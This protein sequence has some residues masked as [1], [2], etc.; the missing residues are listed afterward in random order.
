MLNETFFFLLGWFHSQLA[1][2]LGRYLMTLT[3]PTF[4]ILQDIPGFS[5]IVSH[6]VVYSGTCMTHAWPQQ[7]S[8][9]S[10]GNFITPF[11]HLSLTQELR[12]QNCQVLLFTGAG[13]WLSCSIIS[14]P[15]FCFQWFPSLPNIGYPETCSIYLTSLK[16]RD[17]LASAFWVLIVK[18]CTTA[19]NTKLFFNS[20]SQIRNLQ[21]LPRDHH[22]LYSFS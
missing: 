2:F 7:C 4:W 22:C 6:H 20:F 9:K 12:G 11:F 16:S 13:T 3:T 21:G 10:E 15:T 5:F 19:L 17:L 1:A 18:I 8:W 14:S